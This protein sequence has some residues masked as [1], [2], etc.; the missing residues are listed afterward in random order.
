MFVYDIINNTKLELLYDIYNYD[1]SKVQKEKIFISISSIK[2]QK[3]KTKENLIIPFIPK[4]IVFDYEKLEFFSLYHYIIK[5]G[6][7][8][9]HNIFDI[10]NISEEKIKHISLIINNL[11]NEK[12]SDD[13]ILI[14]LMFCISETFNLKYTGVMENIFEDY[15]KLQKELIEYY[16]SINHYNLDILKNS[17]KKINYK[18]YSAELYVQLDK[19]TIPFNIFKKIELSNKVP[20]IS[21]NDNTKPLYKIYTKFENKKMIE[22][23]IYKNPKLLKTVKNI[24]YKINLYKNYYYNVNIFSSNILNINYTFDEKDD[25]EFSDLY[26]LNK[27]LGDYMTKTNLKFSKDFLYHKMNIKTEIVSTIKILDIILLVQSNSNFILKPT[28]LPNYVKFLFNNNE[29]TIKLINIDV[30]SIILN[31]NNIKSN[32]EYYI[33]YILNIIYSLF[34]KNKTSKKINSIFDNFNKLSNSIKYK[35]KANIKILRQNGIINKAVNCQ[36]SRQPVISNSKS[37]SKSNSMNS[38]LY[39]D[40][41]YKCKNKEYPYIGVTITNDLCCFKKPQT[42]K[43]LFKKFLNIKNDTQFKIQYKKYLITTKKILEPG[44]LGTIEYNM[45]KKNKLIRLGNNNDFYSL[46]NIIN[47]LSGKKL[48]INEI[49]KTI[50]ENT[51]EHIDN[52]NLQNLISYTKYK[53]FLLEPNQVIPSNY[54]IDLIL[55]ILNLNCIILDFETNKISSHINIITNDYILIM[56]HNNKAYE[57]IIKLTSKNSIQ[58]I[59]KYNS[60]IIIG[61]LN[62]IKFIPTNVNYLTANNLYKNYLKNESGITQIINTSNQV[63][64]L[65][66]ITY[67]ILPVIPTY[68]LENIKCSSNKENFLLTISEQSKKLK[69]FL[70]HFPELSNCMQIESQIKTP[71][72]NIIIGLKLKNGL[73]IPVKDTIKPLSKLK[74]TIQNIIDDISKTQKNK[75]DSRLDYIIK[76][77]YINEMYNVMQYRFSI[78]IKESE[79][80]DITNII[81]SKNDIHSEKI[82]KLKEYIDSKFTKYVS[83]QP[84]LTFPEELPLSRENCQPYFCNKDNKLVLPKHDYEFFILKLSN[85]IINYGKNHPILKKTV[86]NYI[87]NKKNYI[88]RKDEALIL[89]PKN[90]PKY[91]K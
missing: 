6:I 88:I 13:E 49:Y 32:Q 81:I 58:S 18:I 24:W 27:N 17:K 89:D 53:K 70:K 71:M 45:L 26:V 14:L 82:K 67:G 37:N 51:Y 60:P 52:G 85:E 34:N 61:L 19:N 90:L 2:N 78:I 79:I 47:I 38:L 86:S 50:N 5:N 31:L 12:L 41:K 35:E 42:N 59:F 21:Y 28:K 25:I 69:T 7:L 3:S 75:Y 54:Y 66:T 8:F 48:S 23:W 22:N 29:I 77:N 65:K 20:F 4:Y 80:F 33:N 11:T 83:F 55:N 76:Y 63:V 87:V 40:N 9:N 46:L 30:Y 1:D 62:Y 68:K 57:G 56:S 91:L 39:K 10:K 44:R 74:I 15:K 16:T 36:K 73:V 64:Y 43:L 72:T 84:Y